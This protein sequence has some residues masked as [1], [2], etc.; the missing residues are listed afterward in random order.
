[1]DWDCDC[2][3]RTRAMRLLCPVSSRLTV[4]S[5]YRLE[6]GTGDVP[7]FFRFTVLPRSTSGLSLAHPT[8]SPGR[9]C[10]QIISRVS[11]VSYR[12]SLFELDENISHMSF[13]PDRIRP[14]TWAPTI[15]DTRSQ[16]SVDKDKVLPCTAR[17]QT[18]PPANSPATC[19]TLYK[20]A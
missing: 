18:H 11:L 10:N 16:P 14:S 17:D 13:S 19:A 15:S 2:G 7:H 6:R 9:T 4:T 12:E 20:P 1:M 8:T 3:E 5:C